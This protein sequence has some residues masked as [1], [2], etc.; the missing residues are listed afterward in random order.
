[1]LWRQHGGSGL[2]ITWAEAWELDWD[3]LTQ[4]REE[5]DRRRGAEAAAIRRAQHR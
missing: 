4:L 1:V 5:V 2:G 3:E